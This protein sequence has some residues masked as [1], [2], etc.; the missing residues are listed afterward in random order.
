MPVTYG[1]DYGSPTLDLNFARNKSLNDTMTGRNLITFTRSS[2]GT[3]VGSDGLI[4]TAAVDTPRFDHNPITGVCNGLLIEESRGNNFLYSSNVGNVSYWTTSN[5]TVS[6]NSTTAPDNTLTA[7]KLISGTSPSTE[8]YV[9]S[10]TVTRVPEGTHLVSIFAKAAEYRYL[11]ISGGEFGRYAIYDLNTGTVTATGGG[12]TGTITAFPN[13]WY[14]CSIPVY[15]Y[16]AGYNYRFKV[17]NSPSSTT[18]TGDGVSGIYVWGAQ[19]EA[20]S[21]FPT[22]YIP[23]TT[24]TVTR[25]ADAASITGT[26]FSS[27]YN[28]SEGTFSSKYTTPISGTRTIIGLDDGTANEQINLYTDTSNTILTVVD[29]G[30]TQANMTFGTAVSGPINSS[31]FSY[32]LNNFNATLGGSTVSSDSSGTIPTVNLMRIGNSFGGSVHSGYISRLT[33]YPKRLPNYQLQALTR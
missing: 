4:K 15:G 33:Y 28:Q 21:V 10:G 24:S 13:G 12:I 8:S 25:S 14:R 26:N 20:Y 2:T 16:S 17:T 3:Y 27:W 23:T 31:S 29:N 32:Q 30:S 7:T 5:A 18:F 22:S 19:F 1:S 9:Y 6:L 11:S